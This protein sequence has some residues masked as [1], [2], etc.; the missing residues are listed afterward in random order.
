MG[1]G[2]FESRDGKVLFLLGSIFFCVNAS[3]RMLHAYGGRVVM[4]WPKL[5][6]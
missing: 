2:N 3:N 1:F 5:S 6:S 4:V